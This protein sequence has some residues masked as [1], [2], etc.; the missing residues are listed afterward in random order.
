MLRI[1]HGDSG[2]FLVVK[3]VNITQEGRIQ[4]GPLTYGEF[5]N[6]THLTFRKIRF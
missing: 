5:T 1:I 2:H 6:L 3:L 4:I